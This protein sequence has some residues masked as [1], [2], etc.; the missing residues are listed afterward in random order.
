MAEEKDNKK[1]NNDEA[2]SPEE[3]LYDEMVGSAREIAEEFAE[4]DLS[5][6]EL[7]RRE[8]ERKKEREMEAIRADI[9]RRYSQEVDEAIKKADI[10]AGV[11]K[12]EPKTAKLDEMIDLGAFSNDPG[13]N[14]RKSKKRKAKVRKKRPTEYIDLNEKNSLYYFIYSLG[15]VVSHFI[16]SAGGDLLALLFV[17]FVKLRDSVRDARISRR[18]SAGTRRKGLGEEARAFGSEIRSSIGNIIKSLRHPLSTPAVI[19]HYI[20]KAV[21]RHALLLKSIGNFALPVISVIILILVLSYWKNVTFALKVIYNDESIGY[22]SD[23]SVFIE[24]KSMVMDRL[25][26]N[27]V[28]TEQTTQAAGNLNAGYE[29]AVVSYDELNDARTISDKMIENSAE[30]LTHACGIYIDDRFICAVKNEADAKTVFYNILAPYE[31]QAQANG[32][33][34]GFLQEI[35]YVQGLYRD[36]DDVMWDASELESYINTHNLINIKKSVSS[37]EVVEVPYATVTTR[38]V[39]KY[40]GYRV[41][42]QQGVYGKKRVTT[43]QVYIDDIL[44]TTYSVDEVLVAP[45]E[46]IIVVGTK[47]TY[48]GVYIGQASSM[49]FLWP[50]P[51]CHYISSPYGWRSSG[52][53]KGVDL[54]TNNGT[55]RGTP[56][57]AS[58]SGVVEVVQHSSSGYGNMILINH[59]D[60]YKTRYA[61]LLEGSITVRMGEVVE[62]GKTIGRVGSTGNS[63]GPHLHFEVIYN[64]ETQNPVNF[65]S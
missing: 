30:N 8:A 19:L 34:V 58:R 60:G 59:G 3:S 26:S 10:A 62:G 45:T 65:I 25:R 6:E 20:K 18:M 16:S 31:E 54:C 14:V 53:H 4:G 27:S 5:R 2:V 35:D 21:D 55:A 42:R 23:E 1:V 63:S 24:A 11:E 56:V 38:D 28:T 29:L 7:L 50:A 49:G 22:I 37:S 15:D 61:H 36:E 46:E 13:K 41:V 64:G 17:P 48:G 12:P 47:T 39:T 52:W 44:S 51:H 43:T 40:S 32:Y 9:E 33:V 57:I